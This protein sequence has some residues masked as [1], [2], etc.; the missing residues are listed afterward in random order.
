MMMPA[1]NQDGGLESLLLACCNGV[2]QNLACVVIDAE[3]WGGDVIIT[4]QDGK[5][6]VY[7]AS[8]LYNFF[9]PKPN[10]FCLKDRA[11]LSRYPIPRMVMCH[12]TRSSLSRGS[13]VGPMPTRMAIATL[14]T[15]IALHQ[16]EENRLRVILA[17]RYPSKVIIQA[18]FDLGRLIQ[19]RN[20]QSDQLAKLV[21][22]V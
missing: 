11:A 22:R 5:T 12:I 10:N 21:S 6:A 4:F 14:R 16:K 18:E 1:A 3:R 15:M 7:S 8:L 20:A 19:T 2:T 17:G 13:T 9:S